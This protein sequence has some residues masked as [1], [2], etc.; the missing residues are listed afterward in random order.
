MGWRING[1]QHL[2]LF[3]L[4]TGKWILSAIVHSKNKDL[5]FFIDADAQRTINAKL[6]AIAVPRDMER[7]PRS[8]EYIK[9]W[10]GKSSANSE[11][12]YYFNMQWNYISPFNHVCKSVQDF[13]SAL[14]HSNS[15]WTREIHIYELWIMVWS[16][17]ETK[18]WTNV[19]VVQGPLPLWFWCSA[20]PAK[21]ISHLRAGHFVV[22]V[23][24][25]QALF[26][27]L[28]KQCS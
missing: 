13:K 1:H 7:K 24:F 9:R 23:F 20:V 8:L 5:A 2:F 4:G 14:K 16:G 22:V 27:L 12:H 25:F 3:L 17:S 21:L 11:D 10:K 19:R 6:Q 15:L 18:A 28:L 26:S